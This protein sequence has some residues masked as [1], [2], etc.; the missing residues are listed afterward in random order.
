MRI[1]RVL[2]NR[3]GSYW[4]ITLLLP[5]LVGTVSRPAGAQDSFGFGDVY[6]S[7]SD[8]LDGQWNLAPT[9]DILVNSS[10]VSVSGEVEDPYSTERPCL[11]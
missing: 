10:E 3:R 8:I 5:I 1:A 6:G 9:D 4:S 11:D 2:K 7:N